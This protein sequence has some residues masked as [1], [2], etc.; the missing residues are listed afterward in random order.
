MNLKKA[1]VFLIAPPTSR[2]FKSTTKLTFSIFSAL[3]T[4]LSP[5]LPIL[6][7]LNR[8]KL[9][10]PK[11][12]RCSIHMKQNFYCNIRSMNQSSTSCQTSY[13]LHTRA[14]SSSYVTLIIWLFSEVGKKRRF[15][16][17]WMLLR[18]YLVVLWTHFQNFRKCNIRSIYLWYIIFYMYVFMSAVVS[19]Y[20]AVLT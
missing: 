8:Q 3:S 15:V 7:N 9:I 18:K 6:R 13:A 17:V 2:Y 16:S 1:K 5:S 20:P 19:R 12:N 11:Q 10:S 14:P 4:K